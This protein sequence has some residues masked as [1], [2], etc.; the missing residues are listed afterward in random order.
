MA[1]YYANVCMEE[2]RS[3]RKE[4][5]IARNHDVPFSMMIFSDGGKRDENNISAAWT[6]FKVRRGRQKEI[7]NGAQK[8]EKSGSFTAEV[9]ALRQAMEHTCDILGLI[10]NNINKLSTWPRANIISTINCQNL[11]PR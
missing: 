5:N 9:Q 11:Q 2:G 3:W 6:I 1:D 4:L 10:F 7:A 8:M